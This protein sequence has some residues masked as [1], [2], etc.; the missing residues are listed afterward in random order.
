METRELYRMPAGGAAALVCSVL[1]EADVWAKAKHAEEA[2][3]Y[4]ILRVNNK[5][6]FLKELEPKFA[7][8]QSLGIR[9]DE[10][11]PAATF[12]AAARKLLGAQP[13]EEKAG[14]NF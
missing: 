5:A 10:K 1:P 4:S 9:A 13:V 7:A 8:M 14:C 6:M 12:W 2:I 11:T 3:G